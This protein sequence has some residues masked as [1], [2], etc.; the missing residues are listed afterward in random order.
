MKRIFCSFTLLL[1]LVSGIAAQHFP[2]SDE[3]LNYSIR[4]NLLPGNIGSMTFRGRNVGDT[5]HVDATMKGSAAGIYT[6][7][8]TYGSTFRKDAGLTPVSATRNQIENSYWAKGSYNWSAPGQVHL[9]VTKSS[10]APRDQDLTWAGTVRDL[11][12]MIWWLRTLDYSQGKLNAGNNALLLDHVALPVSITSYTKKT[13]RYKGTQ[14]PV[15]EVTLSQN[16]K[17]AL[18][19]TLTDD[20]RRLP[21]KFAISLSV[22]TIKGTLR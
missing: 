16:G 17:D 10:R 13:I 14:T 21:L 11:L 8:Y 2:F 3:S 12:G 6:I 20:A 18:S 1:G 15:I 19:L 22:G 7:D 4:H 5:Y 9:Y